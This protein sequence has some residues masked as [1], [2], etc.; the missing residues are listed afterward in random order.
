MWA[1]KRPNGELT[2]PIASREEAENLLRFFIPGGVLVEVS[3]PPVGLIRGRPSTARPITLAQQLRDIQF[4]DW[5]VVGIPHDIQDALVKINYVV[6]SKVELNRELKLLMNR[7]GITA[8]DLSRRLKELERRATPS[9]PNPYRPATPEKPTVMTPIAVSVPNADAVAAE[10]V[11]RRREED[12]ARNDSEVQ[13]AIASKLK[14]IN[15]FLET[16]RAS[17]TDSKKQGSFTIRQEDTDTVLKAYLSTISK[18]GFEAQKLRL[19]I[20]NT[21]KGKLLSI[22]GT[23]G[24]N[25]RVSSDMLLSLERLENDIEAMRTT[26]EG[27][28]QALRARE[29]IGITGKGRWSDAA[30][31]MEVERTDIYGGK[32]KAH[33]IDLLNRLNRI[34]TEINSLVITP[35]KS[36]LSPSGKQVVRSNQLGY[37]QSLALQTEASK[38][39]NELDRLESIASK[40]KTGTE[41]EAAKRR[42]VAEK[43][44][45]ELERIELE[46]PVVEHLRDI[47]YERDMAA[48]AAERVARTIRDVSEARMRNQASLDRTNAE[49]EQTS[50]RLLHEAADRVGKMEKSNKWSGQQIEEDKKGIALTW[51]ARKQAQEAV[52]HRA[53]RIGLWE[54]R[55]EAADARTL[56]EP[57]VRRQVEA[58]RQER[59]LFLQDYMAQA[60]RTNFS[61]EQIDQ[62]FHQAIADTN[63]VLPQHEIAVWSEIVNSADNRWQKAWEFAKTQGHRY[64][65]ERMVLI[66]ETL[67]PKQQAARWEFEKQVEIE[68][69]VGR[70]GQFGRSNTGLLIAVAGVAI[71]VPV[72]YYLIKNHKK[73]GAR[74]GAMERRGP[75][76]RRVT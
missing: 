59:K 71:G 60:Q 70:S 35:P 10:L 76:V 51:W 65:I 15:V 25:A 64:D 56:Y 11:R 8:D 69:S 23:S 6:G 44:R 48:Y 39:A 22:G 38:L 3:E 66:E 43:M 41:E 45:S 26:V 5:S 61:R 28:R 49:W 34:Q 24:G 31:A 63:N 13:Q 57:E 73:I 21:I 72:A 7:H 30:L 47:E 19:D 55:L 4:Q 52:Q 1:I 62:M 58:L 27:A 68:Q 50:T 20:E 36:V 9:Y 33:G 46:R 53:E 74:V 54:G 75:G 16:L 42:R 12:K 32:V 67:E 29:L 37:K 14:G 2:Q 17:W 18:Y 40:G